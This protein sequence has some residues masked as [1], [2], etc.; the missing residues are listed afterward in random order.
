MTRI[1]VKN[2]SIDIPIY[3]FGGNSLKM[4]LLKRAVG[5][6]FSGSGKTLVVKALDGI[7]LELSDGDRI[8]VIGHNGAGKTSLLR[9]LAGVY[10]P[11]RGTVEVDGRVSP[12]FDISLG[13]SA[14]ATGLENIRISGALWGLTDDEI[15]AGVKDVME[16]TELGEYINLPVRT[17][18]TGMMLRLSFAIATLRNP[19]ILLLDEV[20][21]VGDATFFKKAQSRFQAMAEQSRILVVTSHSLQIIYDLCNKC[22]W[23]YEGRIVRFGEVDEVIQE[24]AKAPTTEGGAK[25]VNITITKDVGLNV[26]VNKAENLSADAAGRGSA[27]GL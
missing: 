16:F 19:E 24:Y 12:M 13:M 27:T 7:D 5:G 23:M 26:T 20:I 15:E 21:G 9:M 1:S 6:K 2:A 10:P 11:T 3:G 8:G 18:S 14:D 25:P 4:T 17:Y 22:L